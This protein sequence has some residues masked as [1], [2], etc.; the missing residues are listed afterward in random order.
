VPRSDLNEDQRRLGPLKRASRVKSDTRAQALRQ[1]LP[2]PRG[3][4]VDTADLKSASG[5]PECRFESGRG[6]HLH[7]AAGEHIEVVIVPLAG[8][9]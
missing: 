9:A 5:K 3:G 2:W 1:R 8:R 6:H 4:T 7:F